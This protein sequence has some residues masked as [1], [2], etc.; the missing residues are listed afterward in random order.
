[1]TVVQDRGRLRLVVLALGQFLMAVDFDIVFVALPSIG[2]ALGFA[3]ADL[4][5][6]VS[7]YT[8]VLGGFLLLGGRAADRVGSRRT[9]AAGL[10]L[11]GLA[12]LVGGLAPTA[13]ALIAA[14]AVQG[15][16]AALVVPAGLALIGTTFADGPERNRAFALWGVAGASGAAVGA[17]AGGVLTAT[18]GWQA[19]LLVNVPVAAL[20]LAG[21]RAFEADGPRAPG[22]FDAVGAVLATAGASALVHGIVT[23]GWT[24]LAGLLLLAAFAAVEHRRGAHALLP[25]RLVA[26][27]ALAVPA[28]AVFLFMG[29]VAAAFYL[30]TT[31]LQDV[32]GLDALAAGL[33]F[34]PMSLLA[35]LGAGVAFPRIV[36]RYGPFG[37]LATGL[38]GMGVGIAGLALSL[39]AGS[40]AVTAPWLAWTL[41]AG[42]AFPAV[43]RAAGAAAGPREQ[44][45][46]AALVSTA[47]YVGGA[48][49]LAAI[50]AIGGLDRAA[51]GDGLVDAL[52]TT[53]LLAA[54]V[55]TAGAVLVAAL[56]PRRTPQTGDERAR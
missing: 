45:V 41:F 29:A 22:G 44:G 17:L 31:F 3:P 32:L 52:R 34:L 43:F 35:M 26:R 15:L 19:V 50:L 9:L 21:T 47:Q 33:A 56:R 12:S 53:G 14:R 37:A 2:R 36:A 18:L 13:G 7:A 8:V 27:R 24:A 55:V 28:A 1:M 42:I 5:W 51:A 46:A 25:T 16:G 6:V 49:G 10:A 54:C 23:R 38:A 48:V 11:F 4:Q 20:L 40:Y 39:P 30:T